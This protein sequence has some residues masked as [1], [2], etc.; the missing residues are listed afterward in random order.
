M[1]R[2]ESLIQTAFLLKTFFWATGDKLNDEI[3]AKQK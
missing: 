1:D 3:M 2:P